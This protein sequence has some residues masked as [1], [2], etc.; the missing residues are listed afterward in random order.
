MGTYNARIFLSPAGAQDIFFLF[1]FYK[2]H[3]PK[4]STGLGRVKLVYN[5]ISCSSNNPN[6][7]ICT[8]VV[9]TFRRLNFVL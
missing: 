6:K 4:R 3:L 5:S 8:R 2:V 1:F 7:T 9:K